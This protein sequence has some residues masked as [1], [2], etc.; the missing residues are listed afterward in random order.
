MIVVLPFGGRLSSVV[1][2]QLIVR[3]DVVGENLS[4]SIAVSFDTRCCLVVL[5]VAV[6]L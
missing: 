1:E 3:M 5:S 6:K 2:S 4:S